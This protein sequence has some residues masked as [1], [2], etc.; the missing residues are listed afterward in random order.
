VE[1][2]F[3]S[4]GNAVSQMQHSAEKYGG[5]KSMSFKDFSGCRPRFRDDLAGEQARRPRAAPWP[6]F[7]LEQNWNT[8]DFDAI[9]G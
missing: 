2:Y 6:R 9:C 1:L 5:R 7:L 4:N 8:G 3:D